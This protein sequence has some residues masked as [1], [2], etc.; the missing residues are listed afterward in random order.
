MKTISIEAVRSIYAKI[1]QERRYEAFLRVITNLLDR[2]RPER[3]L[4]TAVTRAVEPALKDLNDEDFRQLVYVWGIASS[5]IEPVDDDL[6]VFVLGCLDS[7][8]NPTAH[9]R[10]MSRVHQRLNMLSDECQKDVADLVRD[11]TAELGAT[12]SRDELNALLA[13]IVTVTAYAAHL[14]ERVPSE[15]EK[16]YAKHPWIP[17]IQLT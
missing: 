11:R 12:R 3:A 7:A 6:T 4:G 17:K 10:G 14:I 16:V 13:V 2:N 1:P 15:L 8:L 9:A 5:S